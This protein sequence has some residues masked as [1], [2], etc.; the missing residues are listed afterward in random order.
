MN[1]DSFEQRRTRLKAFISENLALVGAI[2]G[3]FEMGARLAAAVLLIPVLI[4]FLGDDM[5]GVW[6]TYQSTIAMLS[7]VEF[8]LRRT[9][10]RETSA[11]ISGGR[12]HES[13]D[14]LQ[15]LGGQR[16]VMQVYAAAR[17]LFST[18]SFAGILLSLGTFHFIL[19]KSRLAGVI[20]PDA[21]SAWTVLTIEL[22]VIFLTLP[23]IALLDGIAKIHVTRMISGVYALLR[24]LAMAMGAMITGSLLGIAVCALAVSLLNLAAFKLATRSRRLNSETNSGDRL[25][26]AEF[27]KLLKMSLPMGAFATGHYVMVSIQPVLIGLFL[28]PASVTSFYIPFRL[29]SLLNTGAFQI[30]VP[31]LPPFTMTICKGNKQEAV[32]IFSNTMRSLLLLLVLCATLF[33]IVTPHLM[34]IM[35]VSSVPTLVLMLLILDGGILYLCGTCADFVIA[36]G[37][38]PFLWSTVAWVAIG[39]ALGVPLTIHF[40]AAGSVAAVIIAGLVSRNTHAVIEAV[41]LIK[42]LK[43][44]RR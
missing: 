8:G 17:Q 36:A 28:E 1:K 30:V 24:G 5:A 42:S 34:E 25:H 2:G 18:V 15:T 33:L 12:S 10:T 27:I 11:A 31:R 14:F 16:G 38:C 19:A 21:G 39:A 6:F 44:D 35:K 20:T 23:D 9:F 29:I 37:K 26:Q 41:R 13:G 43:D 32:R 3:W 40:G 22:A 7:C 4:R